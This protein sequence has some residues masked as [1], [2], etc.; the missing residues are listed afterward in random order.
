MAVVRKGGR[1]NVEQPP[2]RSL[3]AAE[4]TRRRS[5]QVKMMAATRST[6]GA[7]A[8]MLGLTPKELEEQHSKDL[9]RGPDFVYAAIT[10]RVAQAAMGGDM[11]AALA[12][13]RQY[14][15]WQ[16]VTRREITGKNGE[17]ISVRNLDDHALATLFAALS[18]GG[19]AGRGPSRNGTQI[20]FDAAIDMDSL[21]GSTDESAGE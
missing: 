16:E 18:A 11:R 17:P 9:E 20:D 14:G 13:L 2:P 3:T 8:E 15:G 21:P 6:I 4:T 10:L 5:L 19:D 1:Q 12:F 7:M